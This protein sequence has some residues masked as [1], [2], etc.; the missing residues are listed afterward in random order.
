MDASL[1][2]NDEHSTLLQRAWRLTIPPLLIAV[3]IAALLASFAGFISVRLAQQYHLSGQRGQ[4]RYELLRVNLFIVHEPAM[5][6]DDDV[7]R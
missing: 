2:L 3:V 5:S 1:Q 7:A 4:V 6:S